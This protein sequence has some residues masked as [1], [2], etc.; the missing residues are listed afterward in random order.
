MMRSFFFFFFSLFLSLSIV[1]PGNE[2][3]VSSIFTDFDFA[4]RSFYIDLRFDARVRKVLKK[5]FF[6]RSAK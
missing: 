6:H 4:D 5:S 1:Y 2:P 3:M